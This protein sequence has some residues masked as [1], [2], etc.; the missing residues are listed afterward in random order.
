MREGEGKRWVLKGREVGKLRRN[1]GRGSKGNEGN[2]GGS[3]G[4]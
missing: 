1:Y 4:S 3:R 2:E